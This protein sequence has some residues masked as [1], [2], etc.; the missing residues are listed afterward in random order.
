MEDVDAETIPRSAAAVISLTQQIR[1]PKSEIR[2]KQSLLTSAA[3]NVEGWPFS[4]A[5]AARRQ[6]AAGV[7]S[8]R[9][10][11]L[12]NGIKLELVL[13]PSGDFMMGD[14]QA[15]PDERPPSQVR[16]AK[17]FWMARTEISNEQFTQ[18]DPTHDSHV[19]S[20]TAYQFG[21][22]G[23]PVNEPPQPVVRVSWHQAMAFCQ[24]LSASTGKKF[25]LPSEAEWEWACRAGTATPFSF[26]DAD[27]DFS[28]F[29]NLADAKLREFSS[30]PYTVCKPLP[31]PT[32]Y[33]DYIPKDTRFNDG[34]LVTAGVASYAP[35]AWG[36][37]DMH[38][39]V[40]EW[41]LSSHRSY[42]YRNDGRND[43]SI[44]EKKVVRGGSWRDRPH[45]ATSAYRLAYE[46]WQRVFNVGFRVVCQD[47]KP[48]N[49][50]A[51]ASSE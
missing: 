23:I 13:I 32:K 19:E 39:N 50:V 17:P 10:I 22:H 45:R 30:D 2:N 7:T 42:P 26:G 29:A 28:G 47:S 27:T 12:G 49:S 14:A 1:N 25:S 16:I 48:A 6:S 24:W 44:D 34:A 4:A 35:N 36:L 41:T 8:K 11:E 51:T 9:T 33:E 3:T 46:P 40:W 15:S 43:D 38:G 18:F 20:K 21:I 37:H 5:E 31:N